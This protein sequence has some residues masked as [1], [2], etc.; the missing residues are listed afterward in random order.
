MRIPG[1]ANRG[2]SSYRAFH[3]ILVAVAAACALIPYYIRARTNQPAPQALPA[4]AVVE[5]IIDGDTVELAGGTRLRYIGIDTPESRRREGNRWIEDPQ[6][7][8]KEATEANRRLVEGK[9]VRL[10]YDVEPYDRYGRTLA[11]V[12]VDSTFVNETLLRDGYAG[13]LTIPPN[14]R[15]VERFREVAKEARE[16]NRGLWALKPKGRKKSSTSSAAE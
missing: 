8:A 3:K 5:R 9:K 10:E 13:L 6:P 12:Y 14:V 4:E 7:Y 1:S 16:A 2:P 11:Y 15:Y